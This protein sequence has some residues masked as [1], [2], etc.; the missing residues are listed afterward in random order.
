[1]QSLLRLLQRTFPA[2]PVSI[3]N[4]VSWRLGQGSPTPRFGDTRRQMRP[5]LALL[6]PLAAVMLQGSLIPQ[7]ALGSLRPNLPLLVAGSWSIAAGAREGVWWAFIG[8]LAADLLSGGPLG[9]LAL[10]SLPPVAA[11]GL[12]DRTL[13]PLSVPAA[14]GLVALAT[15]ASLLL[16]V[17]ILALA[18]Q[19]LPPVVRLLTD[20]VGGAVLTGALALGAYPLARMLSRRGQTRASM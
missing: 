8:G 10:A 7:L 5:L 17:A 4:K 12:G 6:I 11:I 19:P 14:A 2:S 9:A 20:S 18:G 15:F 3:P 13:R 1:M 16:Y